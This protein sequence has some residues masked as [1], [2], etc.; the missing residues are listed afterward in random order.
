MKPST[1]QKNLAVHMHFAEHKSAL[2]GK[3]G[4]LRGFLR[5]FLGG[6]VLMALAVLVPVV[7]YLVGN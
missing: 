3:R 5:E 4:R 2:D 6:I 7:M 1:Y